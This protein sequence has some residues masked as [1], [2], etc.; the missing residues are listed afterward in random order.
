MTA[1]SVPTRS[2]PTGTPDEAA[3]R[4]RADP[5]AP[6]RRGAARPAG[7][8][9]ASATSGPTSCAS[10]AGTA[11]GRPSATSTSTP[12]SRSARGRCGTRRRSP[13]RSR[14]RPGTPVAASSTGW[15]AGPGGRACAAARRYGWSRRCAATRSAAGPGGARAASPDRGR[16][17]PGRPRRRPQSLLRTTTRRR[18][19]CGPGAACSRARRR[20]TRPGRAR[21][22]R[23]WRRRRARG[24]RLSA[25][26]EPSFFAC[27]TARRACMSSCTR[28]SRSASSRR[29]VAASATAGRGRR[30][31]ARPACCMRRLPG[32]CGRDPP[33]C[34]Q[35][36]QPGS[37]TQQDAGRRRRAARPGGSCRWP[38][39]G[40]RRR[41]SILRGRLNDGS[42]ARQ[43]S[44]SSVLAGDARP[45]CSCT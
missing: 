1:T 2:V 38:W 11:R 42:P 36:C 23:A 35:P 10:C 12:C 30:G 39:S 13:A 7:G 43:N 6:A 22:A 5:R 16:V 14:S 8:G 32:R 26:S 44:M 33:A 45:G 37:A 27:C 17:S 34:R 28:R 24:R 15:P 25:S 40:R 19:W 41:R 29:R 18:A 21:P 20:P 4:L 31:N 3:R 9:R